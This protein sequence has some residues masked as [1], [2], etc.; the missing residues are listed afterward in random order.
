MTIEE[1]LPGSKFTDTALSEIDFIFSDSRETEEKKAI[2]T[3]RRMVEGEAVYASNA[4]TQD[5]RTKYIPLDPGREVI[6]SSNPPT[7]YTRSELLSIKTPPSFPYFARIPRS[8]RKSGD[9]PYHRYGAYIEHSFF[10]TFV[11]LATD[12]METSIVGSR[13]LIQGDGEWIELY[14]IVRFDQNGR[15][16]MATE[17][18]RFDAAPGCRNVIPELD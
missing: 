9:G 6:M 10:N 12:D 2:T 8:E 3:L 14:P 4:T 16:T 5:L 17:V 13:S 18:T 7:S 15:I 11:S 1:A